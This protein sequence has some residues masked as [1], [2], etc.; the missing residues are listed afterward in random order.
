M[1]PRTTKRKNL[2]HDVFTTLKKRILNWEYP[3]GVRLIEEDLCTEFSVS[4]SPVREALG[5]L[6]AFGLV[7]N[8]PH[9]GCQVKTLEIQTIKDL[10]QLR[11]AMELY[12][13]E[14]LARRPGQEALLARLRADWTD[15]A[16]RESDAWAALDRS[17]HEELATAVGNPL[18]TQQLAA[19]NERLTVLR[20]FDFSIEERSVSTCRQ[21]LHILDTIA[22]GDANGAREAMRANIE[23]SLGNVEAVVGRLIAKAYLR[24]GFGP[25]DTGD[26]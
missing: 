19:V 1:S 25:S 23:D 13:V 3:P 26:A 6:A 20:P 22:S 11:L 5:R 12:V 9:R 18:L 24:G 15:P 21:H 17:F 10:Y 4:R 16:P 14:T 2:S 7:E 8:T